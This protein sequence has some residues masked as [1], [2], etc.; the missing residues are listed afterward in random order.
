[1]AVDVADELVYPGY[2]VR[3]ASGLIGEMRSKVESKPKGENDAVEGVQG[4]Q[5]GFSFGVRIGC[6]SK[7]QG[8]T[9]G[10]GGCCCDCSLRATG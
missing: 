7:P 10:K 2:T 4:I 3:L 8:A 9:R 6:H 1:M 5:G